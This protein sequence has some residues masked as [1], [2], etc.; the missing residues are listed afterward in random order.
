MPRFAAPAIILHTVDYGES[1]RIVCALTRDRGVISA[2]A[3]GARNSRR[4]FPGTLEPFSD[5]VL[6]LFSKP[7]LDLMRLEGASLVTANLGIREDLALF[8]HSAF[9][10]EIVMAHLGP[11]DPSPRTYDCLREALSVMEPDRQWFAV[12]SVTVVRILAT[13][14][15]G[16]DPGSWAGGGGPAEL[17]VE[18]KAFLA[19]GVRLA[20]DVLVKLSISPRARLEIARYLLKLC[21]QISEKPL[22]SATFLANMLDDTLYR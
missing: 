9:L 21:V 7:N 3:K 11:D 6:D 15:Y 12:W 4:R 19:R 18:A 5:V 2:M 1:D 17:S 20:P 10:L 22:K 14:G 13:L 16:L 8:A